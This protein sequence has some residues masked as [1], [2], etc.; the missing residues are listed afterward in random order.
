M[1]VEDQERYNFEIVQA[2]F[3]GESVRYQCRPCFVCKESAEVIMKR[4]DY[5]FWQG[6][7]KPHVQIAFPHMSA[8]ERELLISGTHPECW[9]ELYEGDD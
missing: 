2:I 4:D 9:E 5:E 1:S 3:N 7:E 8:G 6:P